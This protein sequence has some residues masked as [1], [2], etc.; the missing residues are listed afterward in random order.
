MGVLGVLPPPETSEAGP[1][2]AGCAEK[3]SSGEMH[4]VVLQGRL[5]RGCAIVA[6][7]YPLLN[8][9]PGSEVPAASRTETCV[10][11]VSASWGVAGVD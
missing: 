3:V 4:V 5:E 9:L 8:V 2:G 7:T 1:D 6:R 10:P 11:N